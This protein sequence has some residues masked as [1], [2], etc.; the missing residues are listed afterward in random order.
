MSNKTSFVICASWGGC[1]GFTLV[2]MFISCDEDE[3]KVLVDALN[4]REKK[5]FIFVYEY[6]NGEQYT[7]EDIYFEYRPLKLLHTN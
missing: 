1:R 3:A 5:Y 6:F 2:P 7:P 4:N